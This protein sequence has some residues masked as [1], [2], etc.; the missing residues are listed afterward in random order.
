MAG[1]DETG[2]YDQSQ[3]TNSDWNGS[4]S[5][6]HLKTSLS[7]GHQVFKNDAVPS[8]GSEIPGIHIRLAAVAFV[9]FNSSIS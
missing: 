6:T 2:N 4:A 3:E 8:E 1:K 9:H 5:T 7:P